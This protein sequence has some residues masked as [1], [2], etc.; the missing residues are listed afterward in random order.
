MD[1]KA[2]DIGIEMERVSSVMLLLNGQLLVQDKHGFALPLLSALYVN[3]VGAKLSQH[4]W[5][6]VISSA[7][8]WVIG[9]TDKDGWFKDLTKEQFK[10]VT[11][12]RFIYADGP[13]A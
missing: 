6:E 8:R 3:G 10:A 7:D 4:F 12:T 13:M 5:Q 2:V 1:P 9:S 11:H